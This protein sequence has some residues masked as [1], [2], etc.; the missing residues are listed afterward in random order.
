MRNFRSRHM[1]AL[2]VALVTCA[3]SQA[4]AAPANGSDANK[5]EGP[6]V[7][8]VC[9]LS[10]QAVYGHAKV[11]E[12]ATA[13]LKQ[14]AAQEQTRLGMIG[15]P[16]QNDI[17]TFR[18]QQDKLKPADREAKGKA[19][20][21]RV[22]AYE[23]QRKQSEQDLDAT[24][25][26]ALEKISKLAEPAIVSAYKDNKCGL[27]LDRNV[28]L[29]GNM[30]NDLTPDVVKRLDAQVTTI[31]FDLKHVQAPQRSSH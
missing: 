22:Q 5:L 6:L 8:G 18:Q 27:L 14:L 19:L 10:R 3:I 29:G 20:N 24:R 15:Q 13:R 1:L 23:A 4:Q 7:K 16:L 9:L 2:A 11:G 26:D 17:Q 12:A 21:T 31:N 25:R 28:V 30:G